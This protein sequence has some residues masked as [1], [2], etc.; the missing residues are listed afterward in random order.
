MTDKLNI[1][2]AL[3]VFQKILD[4]GQR[5]DAERMLHGLYASSDLD[6]YTLMIRDEAVTLQIFFHNR[7]KLSFKRR[8]ELDQFMKRL[9]EADRLQVE[10][11]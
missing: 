9:A 7:H 11:T 3:R 8:P 1:K 4:H 6:G 2:Q 5:R 10:Q